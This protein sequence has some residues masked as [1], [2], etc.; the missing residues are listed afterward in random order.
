MISKLFSNN[1]QSIS[2]LHLALPVMGI[3]LPCPVTAPAKCL[4]SLVSRS[5]DLSKLYLNPRAGGSLHAAT[6][7]TFGGWREAGRWD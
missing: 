4:L 6:C 3:L 5:L 7:C 2:G 1:I